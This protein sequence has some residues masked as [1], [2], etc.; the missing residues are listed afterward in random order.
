[1]FKYSDEEKE[2]IYEEGD[3]IPWWDFFE[4]NIHY[5][6]FAIGIF[7]IVCNLAKFLGQLVGMLIYR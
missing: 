2:S 5:K 3:K 1:M 4:W 6:L 7:I